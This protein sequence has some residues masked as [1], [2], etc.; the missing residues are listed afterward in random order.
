MAGD[1]QLWS[2]SAATASEEQA[3]YFFA[4]SPDAVS[5]YLWTRLTRSLSVPGS[6]FLAIVWGSGRVAVAYLEMV[7]DMTS[8]SPEL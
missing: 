8:E 6:C 1:V 3:C 5:R 7:L 4:E 2:R